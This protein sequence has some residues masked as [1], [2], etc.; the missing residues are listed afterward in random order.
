MVYFHC[1]LCF[2]CFINFLFWWT[3][4]PKLWSFVSK[5]F[6]D[7]RK[8]WLEKGTHTLQGINISH[9]GERKIIF[10]MSFLGDMLVSWRVFSKCWFNNDFPWYKV[11]KSPKNKSKLL[12]LLKQKSIPRIRIF[13]PKRKYQ[14]CQMSTCRDIF[15]TILDSGRS[16]KTSSQTGCRTSV[17]HYEFLVGS[18]HR[19][20][21]PPRRGKL[22]SLGGII[23][24]SEIPRP[25]T[26]WMYK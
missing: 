24:G 23:D 21:A 17:N 3:S 26:V 15:Q 20:R 1:W 13:F 16:P 8:R 6:F 7:L 9:L 19:Y 2:V 25:T 22:R 12:V 18:R 5:I 4:S 11:N 10:K 14:Y